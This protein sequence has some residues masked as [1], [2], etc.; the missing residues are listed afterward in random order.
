MLVHLVMDCYRRHNVANGL[1]ILK[2]RDHYT[3]HNMEDGLKILKNSDLFGQR[4][5]GGAV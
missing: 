2:I 4:K 1:K 3:R 5:F